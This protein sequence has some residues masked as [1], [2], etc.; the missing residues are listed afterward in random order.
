MSAL[1]P[2]MKYTELI[3]STIFVAFQYLADMPRKYIFWI[4]G[5]LAALAAAVYYY[6]L[7]PAE[8]S[9]LPQCPFYALTGWQCAGC[10][11]QRSVHALLHGHFSTAFAYNPLL[12]I[13]GFYLVAG[14][15]VSLFPTNLVLQRMHAFMF[16]KV[17]ILGLVILVSGFAVLRNVL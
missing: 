14:W 6:Q 4:L 7:D 15:A 3:P 11:G 9:Y 16:G 13:L 5:A 10:G 12:Y 8:V 2:I 17:G 1:A